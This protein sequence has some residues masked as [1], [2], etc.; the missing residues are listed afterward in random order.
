MFNEL[1]KKKR[2]KPHVCANLYVS[3]HPVPMKLLSKRFLS[4]FLVNSC[5]GVFERTLD[6]IKLLPRKR[7]GF[8]GGEN[9]AGKLQHE[10]MFN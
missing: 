10:I 5:R 2:S 9:C 8:R 4:D 7:N 6:E 3:R 1:N